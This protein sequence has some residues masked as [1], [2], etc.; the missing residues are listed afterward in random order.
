MAIVIYAIGLG[1]K[2]EEAILQGIPGRH[3]ASQDAASFVLVARLLVMR[4]ERPSPIVA[5][6]MN[7]RLHSQT[8]QPDRIARR[9]CLEVQEYAVAD[10]PALYRTRKD[11]RSDHNNNQICLQPDL[12]LPLFFLR[13][14]L[15]SIS[16]LPPENKIY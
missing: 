15:E 9:P 13:S 4:S 8:A 12:P 7:G 1:R 3:V 11:V 2:L 16:L 14:R 6:E 10:G 5:R